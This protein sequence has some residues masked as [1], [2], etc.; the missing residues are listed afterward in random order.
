MALGLGSNLGPSRTILAAALQALSRHLSDT[1]VAPL[2]RSVAESP[3]PQPSY[4]NTVLVG[5]TQL[6]PEDLLAVAK[7]TELGAGRRSGPRLSP[8][9]LDIDLLL[10][11]DRII[12]REELRL[13][14]PRIS[15]RRFV[16]QPLA[17]LQP[18]LCLADGLTVA[19]HLGGLP[20]GAPIE[21]VA[22]SGWH[23][24]E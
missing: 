3:I 10:Y 12:K 17:D 19:Q 20:E 7:A 24:A 1:A 18:Q 21:R 15:L 13:P 22:E 11:G 8:R 9:Q 4:L 5:R 16:L 23:I 2:Y 14:H 6:G